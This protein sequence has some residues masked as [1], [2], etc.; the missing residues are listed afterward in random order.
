MDLT[1]L[2]LAVSVQK[3]FELVVV[4]ILLAHKRVTFAPNVAASISCFG[5][6]SCLIGATFLLITYRDVEDPLALVVF[7]KL[8]WH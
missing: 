3:C 8:W 4:V 2:S 7:T 5:I 6:L 1:H